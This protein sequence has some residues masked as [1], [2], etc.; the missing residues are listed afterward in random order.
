MFKDN[1]IVFKNKNIKEIK[2]IIEAYLDLMQQNPYTSIYY[3]F[4]YIK[5]KAEKKTMDSIY[6]CIFISEQDKEFT[7]VPY[8]IR[9][10]VRTQDYLKVLDCL[11][12]IKYNEYIVNA[13]Q[14]LQRYLYGAKTC[15]QYQIY[16]I[17]SCNICNTYKN[18][19]S[20][21]L[22]NEKNLL[23][24]ENNADL[25]P[26][27]SIR[28][29]LTKFL[30]EQNQNNSPDA[31]FNLFSMDNGKTSCK[32]RQNKR[33]Y[34][35]ISDIPAFL[36]LFTLYDG[37]DFRCKY[38]NYKI[39][40]KRKYINPSKEKFRY[41]EYS[42][43][44]VLSQTDEFKTD[45][46]VYNIKTIWHL[47]KIFL[48]KKLNILFKYYKTYTSTPFLDK[49]ST[50]FGLSYSECKILKK[51]II[52]FIFKDTSFMIEGLQSNTLDF[53]LIF[54]AILKIR[55]RP[56]YDTNTNLMT[57]LYYAKLNTLV[58]LH[59]CPYI[60]Y[61]T[62]GFPDNFENV[63]RLLE[64][65]KNNTIQSLEFEICNF[66]ENDV[67]YKFYY[68][69]TEEESFSKLFQSGKIKEYDFLDFDTIL[70]AMDIPVISSV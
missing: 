52:N 38:P 58:Y 4:S 37:R 35:Q 24:L 49:I 59:S 56:Y 40:L 3:N 36:L 8:S 67:F 54:N 51:N 26:S 57:A 23:M 6:R 5:D 65:N 7:F 66:L 11:E 15:S 50:S 27:K 20:T 28:G 48:F 30:F 18:L 33:F 55:L 61:N 44:T 29:Q 19:Q 42:Y 43:K 14:L 9:D 63:F 41:S 32:D 17:N 70:K 39:S 21:K 10:M 60:K 22:K 25:K 2:D 62:A 46:R 53:M 45:N 68:E 64:K 12:S 16:D 31:K 13:R 47:D 69:D 1:N 34:I